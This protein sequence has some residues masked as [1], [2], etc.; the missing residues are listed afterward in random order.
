MKHILE[1]EMLA[2]DDVL[3]VPQEGV[4]SSRSDAQLTP[5]IYSAPMDTVTGF[6]LTKAMVAAGEIAVVCR[7]LPENEWDKCLEEFATNPQ[8]FFAIGTN[9]EW[10]H[11]FITKLERIDLDAPINV[12]IDIAHGDSIMG[13]SV[14]KWLR[15]HSFIGSIMSGSIATGPGAIRAVR[16]GCTHIRVGIGPGSV[17]TTRLMTGVGVPQLS[18]VYGVHSCLNVFVE[19]RG[20]ITLIADGGIRSPGDAVK[21]LAAGA[22]AIMLGSRF[23]RTL[24]SRGWKFAGH[25]PIDVSQPQTFPMQEPDPIL[26]KSYRGHASASFQLDQKGVANRCPEGIATNEF[27]WD[28]TSTV[29]TLVE[30]FRGGAASAVSYLGLLALSDINPQNTTMIKVTGNSVKESKAYADS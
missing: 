6:D 21:Y 25:Q 4:L 28:G 14:A 30:E 27:Q 24:E 13:H 18:A 11:T 16:A 26:S 12:A 2:A 23:S 5:F 20:E 10:L 1:Q 29:S 3:L 22:D 8:V 7:N 17:C 19:H 15:Q 9:Q